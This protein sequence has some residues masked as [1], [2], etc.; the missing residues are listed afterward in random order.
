MPSVSSAGFSRQSQFF[1]QFVKKIRFT[2]HEA[3][4]LSTYTPRLG[5]I[6]C[7][8]SRIFYKCTE[9]CTGEFQAH[10]FGFIVLLT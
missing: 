4:F 5:L 6:H 8:C 7:G 2:L 10:P 9:C 3:K 1:G